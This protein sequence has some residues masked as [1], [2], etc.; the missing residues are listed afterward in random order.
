MVETLVLLLQGIL[1]EQREF[2]EKTKVM[3]KI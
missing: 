2:L 1:E 3:K